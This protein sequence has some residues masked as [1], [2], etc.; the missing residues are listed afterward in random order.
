MRPKLA[1]DRFQRALIVFQ[2][3]AQLSIL[4]LQ[5][6][7][8]HHQRDVQS[9]QLRLEFLCDLMRQHGWFVV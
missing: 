8:L 5:P 9:L 1:H 4:V 6:L 2:Q 7:V 3:H